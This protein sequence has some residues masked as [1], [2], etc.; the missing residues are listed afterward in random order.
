MSCRCVPGG[1]AFGRRWGRTSARP[2]RPC[3]AQVVEAERVLHALGAAD[4]EERARLVVA[5]AGEDH[6]GPDRDRLGAAAADARD[7]E[8]RHVVGEPAAPAHALR[9][10]DRVAVA[11]LRHAHDD[12]ADEALVELACARAWRGSRGRR[13]AW[14]RSG[15]RARASCCRRGCRRA[16]SG[17]APSRITIARVLGHHGLPRYSCRKTAGTRGPFW[18][19][20]FMPMSMSTVRLQRAKPCA[21]ISSPSRE[22]QREPARRT[23]TRMASIA[24]EW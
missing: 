23:S 16:A 20:F 1:S 13:A 2:R 11:V 22:R 5:Q 14:W 9:P 12:V 8:R 18:M 6:L 4:D 15:R 3:A 24:S 17:A 19:K 10:V 7:G 21:S